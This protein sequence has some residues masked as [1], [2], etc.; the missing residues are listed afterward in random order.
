M[1]PENGKKPTVKLSLPL[2]YY[3]LVENQ[4]YSR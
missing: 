3:Y 2:V 1:P 4:I